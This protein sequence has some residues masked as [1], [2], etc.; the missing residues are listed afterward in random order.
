MPS[1]LASGGFFDTIKMKGGVRMRM[2]SFYNG[3]LT[4]EVKVMWN[5]NITLPVDTRVTA[6]KPLKPAAL[7]VHQDGTIEPGI[8]VTPLGV[9]F[10][11]RPTIIPCSSVKFTG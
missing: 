3:V 4:K 8:E 9:E 6:E 7:Y 5:R 2:P 11:T 10:C 1:A